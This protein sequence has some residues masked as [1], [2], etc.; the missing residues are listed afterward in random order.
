MSQSVAASMLCLLLAA[1]LAM[2]KP[3]AVVAHRGESHEAPE[4][5]M[6]AY[7]LAWERGV[8]AETDVHLTK[9]G[10]L[11]ICHDADTARLAAGKTKL[12]IKDHTADELR[13]LDVGSF[14]GPSYAGERM[15]LLDEL[16]PTIPAGCKLLIE[17]KIGP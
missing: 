14:K 6:A 15:P 8:H 5:T 7:K 1:P 13:K 2:A 12:I 4:N 17:V 11:I 3:P 10:K 16:L 9:D